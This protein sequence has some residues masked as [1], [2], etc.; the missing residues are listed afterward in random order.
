MTKY[1]HK[2]LFPSVRA[3]TLVEVL[4]VLSIIGL[5]IALTI[6]AVLSVRQVAL[7]TQCGN[8]LR[9][10]GIALH[11]YIGTHQGLPSGYNGKGYS[12]HTMILPQL[13]Q[14]NVY[15]ALNFS[16]RAPFINIHVEA[17]TTI[18][19]I[20]LPFFLCPSDPVGPNGKFGRTSYPGNGG[21]GSLV[22][23]ADG[24][25]EEAG[26]RRTLTIGFESIP[27]GTS[28]TAALTE[29][30]ASND[31]T[32]DRNPLLVT[33]A[34]PNISGPKVFDLFTQECIN[35]NEHSTPTLLAKKCRWICGGFGDTLLNFA[36][37]P[38]QHNCLNGGSL[39]TGI[40]SAS[41][42]HPGGVNVL[43]MD[44]HVTFLRDS[45]SQATWRALGTRSGQEV[46]SDSLY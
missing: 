34:I 12:F 3:F 10:L 33:Y 35:A 27:D 23:G 16:C 7:K 42:Y 44:S 38:G 37:P 13:E 18:A 14:G 11:T 9:Q 22:P 15:N 19:S 31:I 28:H 2:N 46:A 1:Q 5:L 40:F 30:A 25:F 24:V 17:N 8:N 39:N 29:W 26:Q 41:S 43:F 20:S 45:V 6:P 36:L 21:Y 32:T 4:V